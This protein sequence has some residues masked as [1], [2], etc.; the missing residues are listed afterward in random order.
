MTGSVSGG[1]CGVMGEKTLNRILPA[2][3]ALYSLT[4]H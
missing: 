1:M 3:P 2:L 4:H